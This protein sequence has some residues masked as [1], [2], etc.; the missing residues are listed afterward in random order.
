MR[1]QH[2]IQ[3]S[4]ETIGFVIFTLATSDLIG[5]KRYKDY[6][7]YLIAQRILMVGL[8]ILFYYVLGP[9]GV[10]MG[11]GISFLLVVPKIYKTLRNPINLSL[12][13]SKR[14]TLIP[15]ID[16]PEPKKIFFLNLTQLS[17]NHESKIR[18]SSGH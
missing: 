4:H 18:V 9:N 1:Q 10:I 17:S 7:L 6:S 14:N 3:H 15:A 8:S 11:I 5:L 12:Y 16:R 13:K 2:N